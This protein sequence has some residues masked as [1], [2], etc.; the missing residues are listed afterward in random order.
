MSKTTRKRIY[1]IDLELFEKTTNLND[2]FL[3]FINFKKSQKM[4]DRTISDYQQTFKKFRK[5]CKVKS[6][7][8]AE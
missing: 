6:I 7:E 8:E 5:F 4:S 2:L 1:K 3:K